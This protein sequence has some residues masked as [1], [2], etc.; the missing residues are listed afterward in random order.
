M[1]HAADDRHYGTDAQILNDL[2]V[3][4]V[5]LL[6]NNPNKIDQLTLLGVD[7]TSREPLWVG[8][9]GHNRFYLKTKA[10]KLGHIVDEG[11]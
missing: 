2:K 8:E 7:V 3:S 5:R 9:N 10:I 1:G 4:S 11:A 6:T